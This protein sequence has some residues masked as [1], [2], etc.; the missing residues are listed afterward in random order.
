[1]ALG[2]RGIDG[3]EAKNYSGVLLVAVAQSV[4]LSLSL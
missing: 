3:G 4:D 1:M 2:C